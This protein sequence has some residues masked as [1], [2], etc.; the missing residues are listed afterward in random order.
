MSMLETLFQKVLQ[1]SMSTS[2][3]IGVLLL[4]LPLI[5]RSYSAKWRYLVWL[6]I[7]VRLL[8][9]FSPSIAGEAPVTIPSVSQNVQIPIPLPANTNLS[10]QTNIIPTQPTPVVTP[11][12]SAVRTITLAD[13]LPVIWLIG[14]ILFMTY[15]FAGYIVFRKS[16]MRFSEIV[17]DEQTLA[18]FSQMKQE[19]GTKGNIELIRSKKVQSP[20]I[21][22]FVK[23]IFLLP[24]V[25]YSE[26]DLELIMKH[27]LIHYKHKDIWN[28]LVMVVANAVHW[29]NPLVY[30]MRYRSNADIEMACDSELVEGTG[31]EFRKQ[32]SET[33]LSAIHKGRER[34]TV[35][36]TYFYGGVKTMKERLGNIFDGGGK[37]GGIVALCLVVVAVIVIGALVACGGST[38][39]ELT[40]EEKAQITELLDNFGRELTNVTIIDPENVVAEQIKEHYT[41]YLTSN[42]L[43][44][45]VLDP[46]LAMGRTTSS[47]WPDRIEVD[48][49]EKVDNDK[50]EVQ[51]YVVWVAS[52]GQN[53]VEVTATVPAVF[54]VKKDSS[55]GKFL[56][57]N[58]FSNKYAFYDTE[59]LTKMLQSVLPEA[60]SQSEPFIVATW[61]VIDGSEKEI[62]LAYMG[63]GGA[64]V[65]YYTL[66]LGQD[67][68]LALANFKDEDGAVGPHVFSEGASVKHEVRLSVYNASPLNFYVYQ[69]QVDRDDSGAIS[70]IDVEA[71]RWNMDAQ[72]FEFDADASQ[73]FKE[74]LENSFDVDKVILAQLSDALREALVANYSPYYKDIGIDLTLDPRA[75]SFTVK[76]G[77]ASSIL[78][79]KITATLK[80]E[81]LED[82]PFVKGM[83]DYLESVRSTLT[84]AQLDA[85]NDVIDDWKLEL[86]GYI[87]KPEPTSY[88]TYKVVARVDD[89]GNIDKGTVKFYIEQPSTTGS[90]FEFYPV[91]DSMFDS[92]ETLYRNGQNAVKEAIEKAGK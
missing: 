30:V 39:A 12:S 22:G 24:Y 6:I 11:N 64:Y 1:V 2:I 7:A 40:A 92:E 73:Q 72:V 43:S 33:I 41:P 74:E 71:Y 66:C 54:F 37:R 50:I 90:G 53:G 83:L 46:S 42:L 89:S 21:T 47:P 16:A 45:W 35:F 23:P 36:S 82:M 76:D 48:S 13:L 65:D 19:M 91:P 4:L 34:E 88:A 67:D 86:S 77:V 69:Y 57:D 28:K 14:A 44:K 31:T 27:E 9:P 32:Y 61:P 15:Y 3:V 70:N 58:A 63:T 78:D 56:I 8:I 17:E 49:M 5:N 84:D 18:T 80:A 20:M 68:K 81:K 85:A 62:A 29:F 79:A 51:G 38:A 87:G 26:A 25:E 10:E 59:E 55:T 52:G 60:G 75:D